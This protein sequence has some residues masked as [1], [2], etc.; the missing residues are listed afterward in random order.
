MAGE[1]LAKLIELV[2]YLRGPDGC[3]WDCAQGYDS[4]KGLLLE[5][6][7][8]VVDAVN[9]R[10]SDELEDE[11]GDLL[12]QVV[13]YARLAQEEQRFTLDDVIERLHAK[14]LRRHPHVFGETW[15]RTP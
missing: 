10:D 4:M 15:A 12:F 7:Y 1:S 14:L 2:A 5:E 3:A 13:F 8:E 11:L 9:K 6:A